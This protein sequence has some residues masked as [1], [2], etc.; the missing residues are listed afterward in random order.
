MRAL[1]L[2]VL[3]R[4]AMQMPDTYVFHIQIIFSVIV[5]LMILHMPCWSKCC[6]K[7][8]VKG[9]WPESLWKAMKL[10]HDKY[11]EYLFF[12]RDGVAARKRNLDM[13]RDREQREQFEADRE[14]RI[15]RI[16]GNPDLYKPWPEVPDAQSW[17]ER[18]TR[19]AMRYPIMIIHGPSHSGKTEWVKTL[20]KQPLEVKVGALIEYFPE[21]MRKFQRGKHDG[22]ILDDVRDCMFFIKHQE[23]I[24]GKYD[25]MVEFASTPGGQCAY[26]RD[27]FAIPIAATIN[28]TTANLHLL[29][30]DDWLSHPGNRVLLKWPVG[31]KTSQN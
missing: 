10:T 23:K 25:Y 4:L 2:I 7:Y 13:V 31:P 26:E 30:S 9:R 8:T 18:F 24:Q 11:E 21:S 3:Q 5:I 20:F 22:L 15:K 1:V 14:Q 16:R 27:L 19:D 12:T 6:K 29:H 17:L 28:D